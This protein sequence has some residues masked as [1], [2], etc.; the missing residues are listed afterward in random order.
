MP[1]HYTPQVNLLTTAFPS[2]ILFN[3]NAGVAQL[4]ERLLPKQNVTGSNPVTRF[5]QMSPN[6][7]T[8]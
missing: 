4:A 1:A 3:T 6:S 5:P 8:F 7:V 2:L